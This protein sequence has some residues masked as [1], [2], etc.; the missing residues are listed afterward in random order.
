ML[1]E[2]VSRF[3]PFK[4]VLPHAC[5]FCVHDCVCFFLLR[6]HMQ[7]PSDCQSLEFRDFVCMVLLMETE[8]V[9][10]SIFTAISP[11]SG[12]QSFGGPH[13]LRALIL[14]REGPFPKTLLRLFFRELQT[15]PNSRLPARDAAQTLRKI[16]R[17]CSQS[18]FQVIN[19]FSCSEECGEVFG[20]K[21]LAY[22]RHCAY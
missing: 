9:Q 19:F 5:G 3:A 4:N 12:K 8:G 14:V 22:F 18:E 7:F 1:S 13:T 11:F 10:M 20:D 16:R 17:G 15:R 6:T 21:F 2:I